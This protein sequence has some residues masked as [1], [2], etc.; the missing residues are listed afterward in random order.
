LLQ[1]KAFRAS[2]TIFRRECLIE[3]YLQQAPPRSSL[4]KLQSMPHPSRSP[5]MI[6]YKTGLSEMQGRL[7]FQEWK[8]GANHQRHH[9]PNNKL[10][11]NGPRF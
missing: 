7:M 4:S 2:K 8:I 1:H 11:C 5:A 3:S 9:G 10:R 6:E